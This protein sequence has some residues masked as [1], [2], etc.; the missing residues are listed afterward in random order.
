MSF[1]PEQKTLE[2]LARAPELGFVSQVMV[3]RQ[4]PL[5][6]FLLA[7]LLLVVVGAQGIASGARDAGTQRTT[8]MAHPKGASR[9]YPLSRWRHIRSARTILADCLAGRPQRPCGRAPRHALE[10]LAACSR[11]R[12]TR[13]CQ[14]EPP[15][16]ALFRSVAVASVGIRLLLLP[17]SPVPMP[18]YHDEF[19]YLLGAD[20][21][22]HG[23]LQIPRPPGLAC[24]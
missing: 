5:A 1:G 9:L 15:P 4:A 16:R 22:A 19:S 23:R 12:R 3:Y 17:F 18:L 2:R 13:V 21:F 24:A 11:G 10:T 20:T 6:A 14:M 8:V 7:L